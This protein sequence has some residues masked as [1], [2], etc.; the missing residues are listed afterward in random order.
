MGNGNQTIFLQIHLSK[1]DFSCS[2]GTTGKEM[3]FVCWPVQLYI[4]LDLLVTLLSRSPPNCRSSPYLKRCFFPSSTTF[5]G[6]SLGYF[7]LVCVQSDFY[8]LLPA[9]R[10]EECIFVF[11]IFVIPY[12]SLM[13]CKNSETSLRLG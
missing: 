13:S 3:S 11:L 10:L 5:S 6:F 7:P 8:I 1:R 2:N 4:F 12:V 9:W